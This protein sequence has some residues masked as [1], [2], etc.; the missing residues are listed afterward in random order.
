LCWGAKPRYADCG[1]ESSMERK[2][3]GAKVPRHFRSPF[4]DPIYGTF[5]PGSEST[6]ERKFHNSLFLYS[7][8]FIYLVLKIFSSDRVSDI[9]TLLG[10]FTV[11][12]D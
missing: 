1:N 4:S 11:Y 7:L 2:F 6:W 10:P 5:V 12:I 8:T 3:L 9:I